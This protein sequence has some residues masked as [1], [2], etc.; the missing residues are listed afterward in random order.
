M[1]SGCF[2]VRDLVLPASSVVVVLSTTSLSFSS[3]SSDGDGGLIFGLV[4]G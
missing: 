1:A 2:R 3:L 4:D